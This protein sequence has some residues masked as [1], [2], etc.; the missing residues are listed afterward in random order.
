M[1]CWAGNKY[2]RA[3]L[4]SRGSREHRAIFCLARSHE[5]TMLT[6]P[7]PPRWPVGLLIPLAALAAACE[8]PVGFC[9]P[10][11]PIAIEV[12]VTDSVSGRAL[13]DSAEGFVQAGQYRDSLHHAPPSM[14]LLYGGTILGTY[15]VTI[16]RPGYAPWARAGIVVRETG[17]CGNVVPVDLTALLQL[18]P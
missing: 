16:T 9:T 11:K 8:S 5:P 3:D 2:A 17:T 10:V 12:T 14:T 6:T 4:D 15:D 7:C 1:T 18:A 13:A